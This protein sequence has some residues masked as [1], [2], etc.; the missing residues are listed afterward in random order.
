MFHLVRARRSPTGHRA[1]LPLRHRPEALLTVGGLV[2][3]AVATTCFGAVTAAYEWHRFGSG[4][5]VSAGVNAVVAGIVLFLVYGN[6]IYQ[7]ARLGYLKRSSA[8][9]EP[10]DEALKDLFGEPGKPMVILVPSYREEPVVIRQTLI[11]AALQDYPSKRVVLLIDDPPTPAD[12]EGRRLLD[13][14]R[15]LPAEVSELLNH[16]AAITAAAGAEFDGD[17]PLVDGDELERGRDLLWRTHLEVAAWLDAQAAREAVADHTDVLFVEQVLRATACHHRRQAERWR[18]AL[19]LD[20]VS[21]RVA[22]RRLACRFA[23]ELT[24]FE[25][26]AYVNLS[27]EPNKAMN[28]NSYIELLGRS[29]TEVAR[30]DG[31]HLVPGYGWPGELNVPAARFVTTV[32]ADSI[33]LPSYCAQLI[34]AI[35]QPGCE[36][37]GVIQTPYSAVPGAA[38][39]LER[40][41]GATTDLQYIVH[42]GFTRH[43]ATFW[44]GAN[45][46]IRYEALADLRVEES[47]R[48]FRVARYIHDRTVIED[49]ESSIDL[50]AA[51]W[52]LINYPQR[53][54][55]SA[56]PPDFG[57]LVVQRRRWANGGLIIFPKLVRYLARQGRRAL[58]VGAWMRAHYLLSIA[59]VNVALL[60]LL[61]LPLPTP[62]GAQWIPLAAAP[63]FVLYARDLRQAGYRY[64]DVVSV[65]ALNL[66]LVPVNLAGVAKSVQQGLTGAKIPFGRTPKVAGRTATPRRYLI[67][68][69]AMV[70]YWTSAAGWDLAGAAWTHLG[71]EAVNV[72]LL[73]GAVWRYVGWRP[74]LQDLG[75]ARPARH[76]AAGHA[77]AMVAR[78][79]A[80]RQVE[81]AEA[82]ASLP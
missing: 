25:R 21:L 81:G 59:G 64:R 24:S 69:L 66:L 52:S 42:Q 77:S 72:A 40:V 53:L 50:V 43:G 9:H 51:G 55:Y 6:V 71:Y 32:D 48:G 26:K 3:T 65:Y 56:T 5:W 27:H 20:A 45:T 70:A 62:R 74:L 76:A 37:V 2:T 73:S 11:S 61:S 44:V 19:H 68:V 18:C 49:T 13:A 67:A 79:H 16:P 60:A 63:Y 28:L 31:L 35:E 8:H 58:G 39:P 10:S 41:A 14:A 15:R 29:W 36:R 82:I 78:A 80:A 57:S 33:L 30:A 54:S 34:H 47:E 12:A 22:F 38:G 17:G 4:A 75:L 1:D 23:A 7:L 46:I